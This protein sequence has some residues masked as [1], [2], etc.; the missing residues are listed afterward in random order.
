MTIPGAQF[1]GTLGPGHQA[2][3]MVTGATSYA[4]A[5]LNAGFAARFIALKS[6]V[7][8]VGVKIGWGSI[9]APGTVKLQIE[10]IDATTGKPTGT[11]YDAHATISFSPVTGIQTYTFAVAPATN[12][13]AGT[14]YAV[15]L[16][17]TIAGTTHTLRAY[18][19]QNNRLSAYPVVVLTTATGQTP[20]SYA[21]VTG[22]VPIC[23]LV[24]S[25]GT[26]DSMGMCPFNTS[27]SN[28]TYST[29]AKAC[30]VTI[31]NPQVVAGV[32]LNGVANA[33]TP[34]GDLRV[35]IFNSDNNVISGTTVTVD[36]DYLIGIGTTARCIQFLFPTAVTLPAGTYRIV[37]DSQGSVNSSNCYDIRSVVFLSSNA[38]PANF[39]LSTTSDVTATPITW[40][41][42]TTDLMPVFLIL[43][44][45]G[46]SGGSSGPWGMIR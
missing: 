38:V 23:S 32:E 33:G 36:K 30:K 39:K 18:P 16:L 9:T 27:T 7:D 24:L 26:E 3:N 17:T 37:F 34:A 29:L 12:L 22:V 11:L 41:D 28:L 6:G 44:S 43:D 25:D 42:N 15:T 5:T 4:M 14:A 21:E 35:R 13:T 2:R 20:S 10:T 40:T 19:S 46:A 1:G 31:A 8:I 45:F